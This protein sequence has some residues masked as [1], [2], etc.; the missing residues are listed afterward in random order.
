VLS[1]RGFHSIIES[2]IRTVYSPSDHIQGG[3]NRSFL[4]SYAA[5]LS[6]WISS[7]PRIGPHVDFCSHHGNFSRLCAIPSKFILQNVDQALASPATVT[8]ESRLVK[9]TLCRPPGR[10]MLCRLSSR[11]A[12]IFTESLPVIS[13]S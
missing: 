2:P 10:S 8:Q 9:P 5:P 6:S 3:W 12:A 1:K 4:Q 7:N 13:S 11:I